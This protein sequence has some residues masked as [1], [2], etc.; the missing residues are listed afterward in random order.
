MHSNM[1]RF[2]SLVMT[3]AAV[4]FLS[5]SCNK[6]KPAPEPEPQK[7]PVVTISNP[8][9]EIGIDGGNYEIS[10]SVENPVENVKKSLF[11]IQSELRSGEVIQFQFVEICIIV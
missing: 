4:A 7:T 5:A 2:F 10:Y 1:K 3:I 9:I 8:I 6:N 11:F